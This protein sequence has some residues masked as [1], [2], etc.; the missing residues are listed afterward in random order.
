MDANVCAREFSF[1]R[2]WLPHSCC[3]WERH[4]LKPRLYHCREFAS[5][6]RAQFGNRNQQTLRSIWKRGRRSGSKLRTLM[7][8]IEIKNLS[9]HFPVKHRVFGRAREF[10]KAVDDVSFTLAPGETLGLVGESGCGKTTLARAIVR[11]IEPTAG[12]IWFEGENVTTMSG[13]QLRAR[14]RKFQMIFQ[15]PH[16]SLN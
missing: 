7:N 11:L 4:R 2:D 12:S 16:A 6:G 14:R 1:L 8:L 3:W 15:D 5:P 9:V 10:V 13:R